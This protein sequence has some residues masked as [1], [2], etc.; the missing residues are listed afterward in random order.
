M[1][2]EPFHYLSSMILRLAIVPNVDS[3]Y[4]PMTYSHPVYSHRS[5]SHSRCSNDH[6]E[7]K[8]RE[9]WLIE[10]KH[11]LVTHPDFMHFARG[12]IDPGA[13][14]EGL[15]RGIRVPRIRDGQAPATN[16]VGRQPRV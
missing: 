16:Q 13:D 4:S 14:A 7:E 10:S 2:Q 3:S 12:H 1:M 11:T 15:F 5:A 6:G 8:S 9:R